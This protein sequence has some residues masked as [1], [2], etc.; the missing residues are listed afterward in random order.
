MFKDGTHYTI[1]QPAAGNAMPKG[2]VIGADACVVKM[3][4]A[5][6]FCENNTYRW[7]SGPAVMT[8][9]NFVTPATEMNSATFTGKYPNKGANLN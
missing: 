6:Y 8:K 5:I 2:K 9:Y 1:L 4:G 3:G 7:I